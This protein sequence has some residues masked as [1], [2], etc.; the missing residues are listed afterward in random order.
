[1]KTV[2]TIEKLLLAVVLVFAL[3][4]C[5]SKRKS[6]DA[7]AAVAQNTTVADDNT[8]TD[9]NSHSNT[10]TDE[11]AENNTTTDSETDDNA[12][13]DGGNDDNATTGNDGDNNSTTGGEDNTT[14]TP[15]VTLASLKLT[16][17]K[18]SLNKDENTTLKVTATYS[19]HTTK[20]V[21][22]KVAWVI[23]PSDAVKVTQSTLTALKDKAVTLKAKL[24]NQTSNVIN[25]NITWVVDGH[26]LPPEPDPKVN[27]ATLLGVDV[28]D[29][30][31]RDDVERWI[32]ERYK[33]AHP[34]MIPL[35]MQAARA[36]QKIIIDPSKAKETYHI[37]D[38]QMNCS[39]AFGSWANAF[40]RKLLFDKDS[41][42]L[43]KEMREMK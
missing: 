7:N 13:D 31:V 37:V 9:G 8:G 5:D 32:Y 40:G 36:Y 16:I 3:G 6:E 12:T 26:V 43:I 1:M 2:K 10:T 41:E 42:T 4:A 30:G 25:L 39:R 27:N 14:T 22:D 20:E 23:V 11:G 28:N 29:N 15:T 35:K 21:T 38:D 19:D 33:D 17:D 24:A 34:I 18:T